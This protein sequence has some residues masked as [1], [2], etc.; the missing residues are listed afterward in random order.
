M[1][2]QRVPPFGVLV[3]NPRL[4]ADSDLAANEVGREF[5]TLIEG[6]LIY[7]GE[8]KLI[9]HRAIGVLHIGSLRGWRIVGNGS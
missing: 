4:F 6:N 2:D 8:L 5:I 9:E 3:K 1:T 7:L